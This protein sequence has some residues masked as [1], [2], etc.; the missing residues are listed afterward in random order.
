MQIDFSLEELPVV[1]QQLLS[2]TTTIVWLFHGQ[3]G[4][5]KTTL[6]KSLSRELGVKDTTA[7][8][9]FSLVNEYTTA[10]GPVYHFDLYRLKHEREAFDF[11]IEEYLYSGHYCFI[12]WPD[13]IPNLLPED[14]VTIHIE[15]ME[16]G[17]RR[18]IMN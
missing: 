15:V 13:R 8:P 2:K 18:V 6:I 4:A 10:N 9:T 12:E 1:A 14:Y 3:M 16:S 7:S 11:G 17:L 5:G